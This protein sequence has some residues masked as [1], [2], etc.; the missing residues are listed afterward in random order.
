MSGSGEL[1]VHASGHLDVRISGSATV[2]YYG[3]PTDVKKSI[4]GS[5]TVEPR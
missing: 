3:N 2:R 1:D 5:G 4:A